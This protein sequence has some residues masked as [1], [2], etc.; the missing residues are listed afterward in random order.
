MRIKLF[1]L[2]LISIAF[3]YS[4]CSS[5]DDSFVLNKKIGND[6]IIPVSF[7]DITAPSI[8]SDQMKSS[9]ND[10]VMI[11]EDLDNELVL[12]TTVSLDTSSLQ[13]K[14][15]DLSNWS[16]LRDDAVILVLI[17][18]NNELY[19]YQYITKKDPYLYL[20][21][22]KNLKLVFYTYNTNIS[23]DITPNIIDGTAEKNGNA[24][25]FTPGSRIIDHIDD[26]LS[27]AD[28]MQTKV[29]STGIISDKTKL[30]RLGFQP[31]QSRVTWIMESQS[32]AITE[33][34]S[35][36]EEIFKSIKVNFEE[37]RDEPVNS[38]AVCQSLEPS[39]SLLL[40]LKGLNT[41]TCASEDVSILSNSTPE[42]YF[43]ISKLVLD[44]KILTD[45]VV[46]LSRVLLPGHKYTITTHI[47]TLKPYNVSFTAGT[48]G[49][50]TNAGI[51]TNTSGVISSTATPSS[52]YSF[53]GW[54]KNG[55][56]FTSSQQISVDFS[57]FGQG[58][59]EARFEST[60][61]SFKGNVTNCGYVQVIGGGRWYDQRDA[62]SG[63]YTR[64]IPT[65][66]NIQLSGSKFW[67]NGDGTVT[68]AAGRYTVK[69]QGYF[70]HSA[71]GAICIDDMSRYFRKTG[72][73]EQASAY[74]KYH[75]GTLYENGFNGGVA[76]I[77]IKD[78]P[79]VI[80]LDAQVVGQNK[81]WGWT[82]GT[83]SVTYLEITEE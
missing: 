14:G 35:S 8:D 20:T 28:I 75:N 46:S 18:E 34:I 48:G 5:D 78:G 11:L 42:T 27:T 44:G 61:S 26:V 2:L 67:T 12:E 54:Y 24:W 37:I 30:P 32:G 56:F 25:Y 73:Y 68:I 51:H 40:K 50:V 79:T 62:V 81:P 3:L 80:H 15:R 1:Y 31:L 60:K 33:C 63:E 13:T 29:E 4:S 65:F 66:S 45:K 64:I 10:V 43:H 21:E 55:E 70:S 39:Q 6:Y 76:S 83:M 38:L 19:Q 49:S 74:Y 53:L 77:V 36:V 82:K 52:D 17:Y 22:G 23:P 69:M 72:L 58:E 41:G 7:G 59:Y 9:Q 57:S 71:G 47:N 16:P